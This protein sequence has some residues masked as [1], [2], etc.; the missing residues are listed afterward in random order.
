MMRAWNIVEYRGHGGLRQ[1]EA[2]WKHLLQAMPDRGPQHA[3]ETSVA[4]FNHLSRA[5]DRFVCFALSDGRRV[6]AI[7]PLEPATFTILGRP[8]RVWGLACDLFDLKRD[9]ICP[10]DDARRELLPS[11][12]RH[13]RC[14]PER[15]AWLVFDQVREDSVL[16][17]C[18]RSLDTREYCADVV[19]ASDIIDCQR[20]FEKTRA[21]LSRNFRGN[22]RKARNKLTSLVDVRFVHASD[23]QALEREFE[24]FLDV[25]ASGWKGEGGT[26]GALRAKPTHVAFY[27]DLVATFRD[28]G[29]CEINALYA[30]G[31]CI[32]SQLCARSGAEYTILKIGY[33]ERYARVAP[34]QLL[35]ERTLEYCCRDPQITRLSLVSGSAWHRDW[36]PNAVPVYCAHLALGR[37]LGPT[38]LGILRLRLRYGPRFK[39][40]LLQSRI[41]ARIVRGLRPGQ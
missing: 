4:Y 14:A 19:G 21:A 33:D 3:W 9:V 25:E 32:A 17:G 22:L 35:L 7:C 27:R 26:H 30:E 38:L 37:W 15:P 24:R 29:Q 41:G 12:V 36:R 34:G 39:G 13:L 11:L 5:E 40:W 20:T 23:P 16:W 10:P 28:G 31:R 1:L 8:T 2:D 6:R 18:L